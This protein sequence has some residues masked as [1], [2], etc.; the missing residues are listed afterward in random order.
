MTNPIPQN[1]MFVT[2]ANIGEL[3]EMIGSIGT[4]EEQRL[5]WLGASMALNLAH[6]LHEQSLADVA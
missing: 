2:P 6:Q 3:A 4:P 1:K 5:A